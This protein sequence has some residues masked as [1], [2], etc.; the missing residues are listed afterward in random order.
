[1]I[2]RRSFWWQVLLL[3]GSGLLLLGVFQVWLGS[4]VNPVASRGRKSPEVPKVR[5]LRDLLPLKDFAVVSSKNLFSSDRK[6]P[7]LS[8][9]AKS[10]GSLE[11]RTLMGTIIIGEEKAALISEK[12]G[13]GRKQ[14]QVQVVRLGEE[15]EGFKVVEISNDAVV[16]EGK[17]GRKTLNFPE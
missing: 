2:W 16:F 1:L 3:A 12:V 11:G 6:G 9:Q 7:D 8:T 14:P 13:K 5:P 15:W 17:D 4:D 10:Q